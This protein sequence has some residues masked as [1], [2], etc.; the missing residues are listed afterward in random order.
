MKKTF[1]R[2][3]C[4][5]LFGLVL[6][7]AAAQAAPISAC[8]SGTVS[9]LV[10]SSCSIGD[11]AFDFSGFVGDG[12]TSA[13][14]LLTVDTSDA[15]APGFTL[16][17]VGPISVTQLNTLISTR[18][19]GQVNFTVSTLSGDLTLVGTTVTLS[20]P[21]ISGAGHNTVDAFLF[22]AN[23]TNSA[24]TAGGF[25]PE[26]CIES[27]PPGPTA[28]A[29]SPFPAS[30]TAVGTFSSPVNTTTFGQAGFS[31]DAS[32]GTA[33]FNSATY[34]FNQIPGNPTSVPEP[35]TMALLGTGLCGMIGRRLAKRRQH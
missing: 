14:V 25:L 7:P 9:T 10:G 12:I 27:N 22:V 6:G 1:T 26:V 31:V 16:T 20:N 35:S 21:A 11:K 8:A 28:C 32:G 13:D 19:F 2:L 4:L 3:G 34:T 29:G 33:T 23:G 5:V 24:L 15:L 30:L 17:G 18:I